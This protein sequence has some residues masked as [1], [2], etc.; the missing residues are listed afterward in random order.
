M[1]PMIW[2]LLFYSAIGPGTI[3]DVVQQ[4][5]QTKVASASESNIIL[6]L[7]PVCTAICAYLLL[8]ETTTLVETIGGGLILAAALIATI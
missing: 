3:A 5:G 4:Q 6:S 8:G 2:L 7:E 1:N